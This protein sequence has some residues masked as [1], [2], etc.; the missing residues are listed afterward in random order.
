MQA[1][2]GQVPPLPA[3]AR[4]VGDLLRAATPG[5]AGDSGT[6]WQKGVITWPESL[7]GWKTL[8]DCSTAEEDYDVTTSGDAVGAV[9]YLIQTAVD[10]PRAPIPEMAARARRRIEAITSQA[11]AR[12]LWTGALSADDPWELP[13]SITWTLSNHSPAT[14]TYVNP[15]LRAATLLNAADVGGDPATLPSPA[16]ALG[17]VESAVADTMVG[18]PIYL[19]VPLAV[20]FELALGLERRGD[21]LYTPAGSIVVADGGYPGTSA[22]TGGATAIYGTGPVQVWLGET[23]VYDEP[24]W[25]V[26]PAT[27]V[28]RV[29]AERP[30][31]VL[32][33]PQ[34]LVG[35]AVSPEG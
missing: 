33:D 29:W 22:D 23:T 8:L 13:D 9:P 32:F 28:A 27:N 26:D 17:M 5:Q 7:A 3:Q 1:M 21:L 10:C 15:Y 24:S 14:G 2:L 12:E 34:T 25:V 4:R 20:L 6:D 18:G 11:V 19:H 35:A 30:A 16:A 31:L